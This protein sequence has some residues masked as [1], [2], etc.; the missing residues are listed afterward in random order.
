MV[1]LHRHERRQRLGDRRI[2]DHGAGCHRKDEPAIV[3]TEKIGQRVLI[4]LLI[5][6]I[7]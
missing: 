7:K 1:L 6:N 3:R 2:H 4:N 5:K